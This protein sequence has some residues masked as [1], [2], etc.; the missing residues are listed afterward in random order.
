MSELPPV[1]LEEGEPEGPKGRPA[2]RV[3]GWVL[4]ASAVVPIGL[5]LLS[6]LLPPADDLVVFA[7]LFVVALPFVCF[8]LALV[9]LVQG[10]RGE[11]LGYL[12]GGLVGP[13]IGFG[14]CLASYANFVY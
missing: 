8:V 4:L 12:L 3:F 5:G 10:H 9:R 1:S 6:R 14:T 2:L 7:M 13:L 11:A